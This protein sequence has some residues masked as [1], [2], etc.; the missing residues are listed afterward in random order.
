MSRGFPVSC[1]CSTWRTWPLF[2][3]PRHP[4]VKER[5]AEGDGNG[6]S[7]P[8]SRRR[9]GMRR[10]LPPL[11]ELIESGK[12]L[13]LNMPAGSNPALARASRRV[14][15]KRLAP[16]PAPAAGTDESR[17]LKRLLPARRFHLRRISILRLSR[18][19]GPLG[20]REGVCP[21][22]AVPR[23]PHRRHPIHILAPI[24]PGHLRGVADA[25]ADAPH[26]DLPLPQRRR[27]RRDRLETL[28]A[29]GQDQAELDR[30]RIRTEQAEVSLLLSGRAGGSRGSVGTSKSFREQ[31]EALFQPREF[32]LASQLPGDLPAL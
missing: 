10:L 8:P 28:R 12:V 6:D 29:G 32:G 17:S 18:R 3:V 7:R 19:G 15:Q 24:R 20:R 30:H 31:R 26:P 5:A 11:D 21:H 16:D 9:P 23:H 13:A 1:L 27:Q 22:P 14:P 2:S 25:L 4:P